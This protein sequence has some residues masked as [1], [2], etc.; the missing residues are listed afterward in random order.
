[1]KKE[2]I[3]NG[4]KTEADNELDMCINIIKTRINLVIFVIMIKLILDNDLI[5]I[6]NLIKSKS[7]K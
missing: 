7:Q 6:Y 5:K 3:R 4:R 1:M 2:G